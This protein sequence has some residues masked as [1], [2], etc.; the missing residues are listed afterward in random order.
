MTH[1]NGNKDNMDACFKMKAADFEAVFFILKN[2]R[3]AD[4]KEILAT[5]FDD[6]LERITRKFIDYC[7]MAWVFYDL[8]EKPIA[9]FGGSRLWPLVAQIGFVATDDWPKIAYAVSRWLYKMRPLLL[10]HYNISHLFCFQDSQH[11]QSQKWLEWLGFKR[12]GLLDGFGSNGEDI[13]IM[14]LHVE[15]FS[16]LEK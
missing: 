7:D 14:A 5:E 11:K 10:Q 13:A 8:S 3:K 2:M 16:S 4:R 12:K 6:N 15:Y 1:L 9:F